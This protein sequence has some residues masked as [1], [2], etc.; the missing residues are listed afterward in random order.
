M[1]RADPFPVHI[2]GVANGDERAYIM[3]GIVIIVVILIPTLFEVIMLSIIQKR[4]FRE[5]P[6]RLT[7]IQEKLHQ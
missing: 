6:E 2:T 1:Q 7:G 4:K 3:T 5:T